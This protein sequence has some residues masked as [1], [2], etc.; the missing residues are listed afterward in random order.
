[1]KRYSKKIVLFVIIANCVFA[2]TMIGVFIVTRLEP[3]TLIIS[4]FAF[5]GTELL[6]LAGIKFSENKN[7]NNNESEEP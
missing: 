7:S 3:T 4:W 6:A 2:A 5:T 1:M